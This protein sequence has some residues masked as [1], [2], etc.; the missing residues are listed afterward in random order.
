MDT[1]RTARL[2]EGLGVSRDALNQWIS[3][4]LIKPEAPADLG[5]ARGWA[6]RDVLRVAI[7]ARLFDTGIRLRHAEG[8]GGVTEPLIEALRHLRFFKR[9]RAFLLV[10]ADLGGSLWHRLVP[11]AQLAEALLPHPNHPPLAFSVVIDLD[12][13]EAEVLAT[14]PELRD[15]SPAP[16]A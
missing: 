5:H 8:S 9:D 3:R 10:Q 13:I 6:L 12:A 14:F 11:G 15:S 7:S 1:I 16:A 4:G 2:C